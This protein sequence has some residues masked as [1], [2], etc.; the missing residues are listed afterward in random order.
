MDCMAPFGA[1]EYMKY[2]RFLIGDITPVDVNQ[3]SP[4]RKNVNFTRKEA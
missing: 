4:R 2:A 3:L 1:V